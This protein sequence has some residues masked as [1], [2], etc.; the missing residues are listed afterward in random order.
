MGNLESQTIGSPIPQIQNIEESYDLFSQHE[1]LPIV[2]AESITDLSVP[3]GTYELSHAMTAKK[4]A[5]RNRTVAYQ[6]DIQGQPQPVPKD[7]IVLAV[8]RVAKMQ[9]AYD[10][11]PSSKNFKQ[12]EEAKL[13]V[14][15]LTRGTTSH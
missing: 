5:P 14:E 1:T 11:N 6:L 2:S 10:I 4:A 13:V 8:K 15:N 9:K 3:L 12:L 7:S